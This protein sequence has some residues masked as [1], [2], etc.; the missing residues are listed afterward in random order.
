MRNGA[1]RRCRD[2]RVRNHDAAINHL[3]LQ[4][5][6]LGV[7]RDACWADCGS[8]RGEESGIRFDGGV[9]NAVALDGGYQQRY[10]DAVVPVSLGPLVGESLVRL[11]DDPGDDSLFDEEIK[12]AALRQDCIDLGQ[13]IVKGCDEVNLSGDLVPDGGGDQAGVGPGAEDIILELL[14]VVWKFTMG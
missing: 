2:R 14:N 10:K 8:C 4:I 1:A 7:L 9:L 6:A 5:E 12:L 11:P 3:C 13:G